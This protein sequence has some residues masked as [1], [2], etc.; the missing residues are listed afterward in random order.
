MTEYK[1]ISA[2]DVKDFLKSFSMFVTACLRYI[3]KAVKNHW[4][5]AIITF[6]I[7]AGIG[8]YRITTTPL[9][10]KA[11]MVCEFTSLSKKTYGEMLQQLNDLA[12][13]HSH[14]Q[15]AA[16]LSIPENEANAIIEISGL[17]ITGT[18]LYDDYTGDR[19]PMYITV[20]STNRNVFA[21]LQ[22]QLP[23][24]LGNHSPFR[25]KR[26]KMER[27]QCERR[28]FQFKNDMIL[29]DSLISA[30]ALHIK[31]TT[32]LTDS[33]IILT[34]LDKLFEIKAGKEDK[35]EQA[36]WRIKELE[37]PIEVL[38][39]FLPAD[40]PASPYSKKSWCILFACAAVISIGLVTFLCLIKDAN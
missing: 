14:A 12:E 32:T 24:Y 4:M 25:V 17:N 22:H 31:N 15:L 13:N 5:V 26:N 16:A 8:T 10:Y 23:E 9:Q 2:T 34:N 6:I 36:E 30:Y 18:P 1:M 3:Y 19:G 39:G 20:T 28:I 33:S 29:L 35:I 21:N 27:E 37:Q 11:T 38:Y 7:I 40:K